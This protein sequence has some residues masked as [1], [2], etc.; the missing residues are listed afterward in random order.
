MYLVRYHGRTNTDIALGKPNK[1]AELLRRSTMS[2]KHLCALSTVYALCVLLPSTFGCQNSP[3]CGQCDWGEDCELQRLLLKTD[4]QT[5]LCGF[6]SC[7]GTKNFWS[8]TPI[9][10]EINLSPCVGGHRQNESQRIGERSHFQ[11]NNFFPG[12]SLAPTH[13]A[14]PVSLKINTDETWQSGNPRVYRRLIG[15]SRGTRRPGALQG[16]IGHSY[17]A[18]D[19][20][21]YVLNYDKR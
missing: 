15:R 6:R 4:R 20:N 13:P 10:E 14:K 16:H 7:C 18:E 21:C 5:D 1:F 17:W 19:L 3:W 12:Y 9:S 8:Q 2:L 11:L